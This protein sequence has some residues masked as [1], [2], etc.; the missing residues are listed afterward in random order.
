[1]TSHQ[2]RQKVDGLW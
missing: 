1:M 2:S